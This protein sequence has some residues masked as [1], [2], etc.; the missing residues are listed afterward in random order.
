MDALIVARPLPLAQDELLDLAGRRLGQIAEGDGG[1][2]LEVGEMVAAEGDELLLGCLQLPVCRVTNA[3]GR[4]PQCSSGTATTAHSRTA[5]WRATAC[6]TSMVEMFSPPEMMMSFLR[7]RSSMAPSGMHHRQI[8]GV[9]PAAEERPCRR[10]RLPVVAGHDVLA[11]HDDFAHR[12][13]VCRHLPQIL[14]HHAHGIGDD[15]RHPL[16]RL[17]AR[18]LG[19]RQMRPT[20]AA[21]RRWCSVRTSRSARR[22]G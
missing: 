11:A 12:L 18:P 8:A 5:G 7:S 3:F 6:S 9:E 19:W 22:C 20:R 16:P 1:R 10:L 2:A 15:E 14:V 13:A 4:S 17:Q 21:P